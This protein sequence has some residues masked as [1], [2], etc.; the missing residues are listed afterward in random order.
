[1]NKTLLHI[2]VGALVAG[3]CA[4]VFAAPRGTSNTAREYLVG[5]SELSP[6]SAGL[7][8]SARERHV[9][10]NNDAFFTEMKAQKV[11]GYVG[12]DVLDWATA[13]VSAGQTKA[14]INLEGYA[15]GE[16]DFGIG[17]LL[18]LLD[19]EVP[20]PLIMEDR[21]R[22]NASAEYSWTKT[23]RFGEDIGWQEFVTSLT[24][25]IVNDTTG[26]KA[27]WPESVAIFAGPI[28]SCILGDLDEASEDRLGLTGGVEIFVS[29]RVSLDA[30]FENYQ[31]ASFSGGLNVRF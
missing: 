15:D 21:V 3:S 26:N 30:R 25:S 5:S 23:E 18:N 28:Y 17:M 19:H 27:F 31:K 24:F 1:M 13:Y 16:L 6:W 22:V 10:I 20:D 29:E 4:S 7:H 9:Q 11:V 2:L 8:Y 14:Q 12:Y